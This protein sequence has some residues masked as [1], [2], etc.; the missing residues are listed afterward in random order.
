MYYRVI[1]PPD[2]LAA[3]VRYFW[4]LQQDD[5]QGKIQV[6]HTIVDDSSGIIFQRQEGNSVFEYQTGKRLNKQFI[7]GQSTQPSITY[8]EGNYKVAG[9]H[10][11][12]HA[13]KSLFGVDAHILSDHLTDIHI[14]EQPD[15]SRRVEESR[16][17]EECI[18]LLIEFLRAPLKNGVQVDLLVNYC[19]ERIQAMNGLI[20]ISDLLEE[21]RISERQLQRRF[22]ISVGI[23]PK[24]YIRIIRFQYALRLMRERKFDKLSDIAFELNYADQAHFI[25]DIREFSGYS[26]KSL[27]EEV[28][29]LVLNLHVGNQ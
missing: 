13:L 17:D 25:R 4:I 28:N 5:L 27:A 15:I 14:L 8:A 18:E 23:P 2:F 3:Y 7:Y 21:C 6:L 22:R 11:H 29:E 19:I 16:T 10:F 1:P 9:I 26:P 20:R 24:L 12:P